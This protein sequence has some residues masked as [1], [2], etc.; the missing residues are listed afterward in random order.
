MCVCACVDAYPCVFD[1]C[2]FVHVR[3]LYTYVCLADKIL[4]LIQYTGCTIH[5]EISSRVI[6][7]NIHL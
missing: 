3:A 2:M 6:S 5:G 1:E 4:Y 7:G